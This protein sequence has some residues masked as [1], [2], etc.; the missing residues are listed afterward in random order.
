MYLMPVR[1]HV[2]STVG[3]AI[4]RRAPPHVRT[5]FLAATVGLTAL[6]GACASGPR[7][8]LGPVTPP[9]KLWSPP[10]AYPPTMFVAGI[11]GEVLLQALVDSTGHVVPSSV[12][13]VRSSNAAFDGPAAAMLRG[14]RFRPARQGGQPV[15]AL[16]EVPVAF[17]LA[18]VEIDSAGAHEALA[19]AERL[20][21]RGRFDEAAAAF[22]AAQTADPR[23]SSSPSFWFPLCWYGTLWDHA[24]DVLAACDDLV[25]L[26]PDRAAARRARGMARA[27]TGDLA[28]ARDDFEA[29]LGEPIDAASAR[30]LQEWI[31]ELR[32]G[33]NPVTASVLESLRAPRGT[34]GGVS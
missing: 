22:N 16:V 12:R 4:G 17:A 2:L 8:E 13:V 19:R 1:G 21:R 29:A 10:L 5:W 26:V 31:G 24:A 11:E 15:N 33:R 3:A 7:E 30:V 23:L 34:G 28:G 20:I 9:A 25:A 18:G 6:S 32:A 14:T 27:V